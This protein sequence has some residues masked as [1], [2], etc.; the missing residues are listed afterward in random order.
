MAT[1][2]TLKTLVD[3]AKEADPSGKKEAKIAEVLAQKNA[4]WDEA[5][6]NEGNLPTGEQC[7]IRAGL[8]TPSWRMLNSGTPNTKATSAQITFN[9]GMLSDRSQV[10]VKSANLYKDKATFLMNESLAHIEG[11]NQ[12]VA[13]TTFYGSASNPEEFVGFANIY[14]ALS[15]A[16]NS[17]NL[18]TAGGSGSDNT[19][20]YLIGWGDQSI[21]FIFPQGSKAGLNREYLGV[22]DAFDGSNNRFRAH[23]DSYEWD[24]GLVVKD[25]RYGVRIP[26]VDVSDLV[27]GTGTQATT[28]STFLP[29]LMSRA[30]D[31]LPDLT[32]CNPAFYMNR[33]A[34]SLLRV[35]ARR[36]TTNAVTIEPGL[37][38]F[39]KT[40]HTMRYL[41]IPVR[42]V[43]ALLNTESVVS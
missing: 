21:Y 43:D 6:V 25:W 36:G 8:P 27:A 17:Q 42:I 28:A 35:A 10:D 41:G 4:L 13:Q 19:S 40:I 18:I 11:M 16:G 23:M 20:V 7:T 30:I 39:G 15:G 1:L 3:R 14:S 24:I 33:T 12:E 32:T 5:V 38:Q 29:D 9:C 31:R 34:A 2:G 26:N 22:Q 37:N